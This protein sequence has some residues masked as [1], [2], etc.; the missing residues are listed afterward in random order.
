[1]QTLDSQQ[2]P[3]RILV[4]CN[5][6]PY[7]SNDGGTIATLNMIMGLAAQGNKVDVL[8]MQTPKHNF[9]LAKL[10]DELKQNIDWHSVWIDT[11]IKLGQLL[12]NLLFSKLPY[13]AERFV[14]EEFKTKL[15]NLL[16][17]NTYD[18]VQ[19]EG[20]YLSSYISTIRKYSKSAISLRSHNVEAQIW[21]RLAET[22]T[23]PVKRIYKRILSRRIGKLETQT[24][25]QID[26][27][28]PI[29]LN[30]AEKLPFNPQCTYV[31]PTGIEPQKFAPYKEP[32]VGKSLFYIGALDWEPNQEAVLWFVRNVW[33]DVQCQHPDWEFHIAGRNAPSSFARE[34]AK[35]PVVFDGQVASAQEFI[36]LHNI[37][38][39]P[40][41]SGSGMRIKIIEAMAHSRCVVT[42]PIGAEGIDAENGRQIL[43]GSSPDELKML[44]LK[45]IGDSEYTRSVADEA[46]AYTNA[47]FSNRVIISGLNQFYKQ[48]LQR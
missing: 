47:N 39:V 30:D 33:A 32:A 16:K 19:L 17:Q 23:N 4:L 5:K 36:E 45:A 26:V 1:M 3:L 43:I 2:R 42:T 44:I 35:Y 20:L 14:S 22:E 10:S 24:L 7:P 11:D 13:N 46:F 34:L 38:V 12:K 9:P 8:A 41:L 27:L 28:V 37:M 18:I 15:E 21:E 40:L 25:K 29:T 31:T 48:W 6:M